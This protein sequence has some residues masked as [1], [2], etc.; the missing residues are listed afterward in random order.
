MGY[1][2]RWQTGRMTLDVSS[3]V[4]ARGAMPDTGLTAMAG[5]NVSD[6]ERLLKRLNQA[7][8]RPAEFGG[9]RGA[10]LRTCG[11]AREGMR[12]AYLPDDP[13]MVSE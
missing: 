3:P 12:R 13:V 4:P 5:D 2:R 7:V 1:A 11:S 10:M 9:L 6:R 8:R